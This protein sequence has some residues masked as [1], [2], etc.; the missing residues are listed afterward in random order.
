MIHKKIN[1]ILVGGNRIN[2]IGPLDSLIKLKKKHKIN[3]EFFTDNLHLKKKVS[4][5]MSFMEYLKKKNFSYSLI[6]SKA[7]LHKKLFLFSKGSNNF[8]LLCNCIFII[9][10]KIIRLFENRIFNYHLASLPSQRGAA[11]ASWQLMEGSSSSTATI[12]RVHCE[13]DKGEIV[14]EEDIDL[15]DCNTPKEFYDKAR[16]KEYRLFEK[17][18]SGINKGFEKTR[19]QDERFS[20]Y[21]PRLETKIHSFIDWSWNAID[22]YKFIKAFDDPYEGAQSFIENKLVILKKVNL[23]KNKSY[24]FHPYQNGIIY[25]VNSSSIFIAHQEYSLVV[26]DLR[27]EEQDFLIKNLLGKRL[28]T[29]YKYLELG[30]ITTVHH[31]AEK[32]NVRKN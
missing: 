6:K 18:L 11:W 30:Y 19:M 10:K 7:D 8:I 27:F 23:L 22:I 31:T 14:V 13:I 12:H 16:T 21:M 20:R 5:N 29:P 26:D 32:I 28:Y 9:N 1:L 25:K 17:F 2:E 15:V 4:H 3:I 24:R